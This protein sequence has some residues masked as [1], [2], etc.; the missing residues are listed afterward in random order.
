[1]KKDLIGT[2]RLIDSLVVLVVSNTRVVYYF[3]CVC[4]SLFCG[5]PMIEWVQR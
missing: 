2:L 5:H 3:I 1:M 4:F